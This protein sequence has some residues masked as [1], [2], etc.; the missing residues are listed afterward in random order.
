MARKTPDSVLEEETPDSV[1]VFSNPG[2]T[3][4]INTSKEHGAETLCTFLCTKAVEMF[5]PNERNGKFWSQL[6]VSLV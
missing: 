3:S 4:V 6:I 5:N 2:A 1:E